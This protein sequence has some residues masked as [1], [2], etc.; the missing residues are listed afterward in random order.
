MSSPRHVYIHVPFCARR[1]SYC[2][3]SIAV[4]RDVPVDDYLTS[5]ETE[6]LLRFGA[7]QPTEVDTIYFGGGT[8]SRL[9]GEGLARALELV[10]RRFVATRGA[11]ITAEA[12]P[13]DMAP[14]ALRRWRA[15]GINR[16]SIGSQSFDDRVLA[17][18]HRTHDARAIERAVHDARDAGITNLS[19]DLIFALP[20]ALERDF[21]HDVERALALQP[22]HVSLY[23]LTVEPATPLGR[24]VAQGKE[25][26]QPEEGYEDEFLAAHGLLTGA[27]FEH[28]EVS[29]YARPG[30]RAVHN[31]AYWAGVP[32]VGL[33]PSAHEFDGTERRWNARAW[34]DWRRLLAQGTDPREGYES[35][36]PE[37]RVAEEV[38]LG[39][40]SD[41]GLAIPPGERRLVQP[42]LDAGWA[43]LDDDG[44]LRC[45]AH[46][47]LRLDSLA[48]ALTHHRSR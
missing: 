34:A 12:N 15:A 48:A 35:L 45:T 32:Y 11:E 8:P 40:R 24:W 33:G 41:H 9:G 16:L 3:F 29:N 6:L 2:D 25:S 43:T 1:C 19:L 22:D 44:V 26:E 46:G 27:G 4:R 13:D 31:S 21:R 20:A 38:Y 18:M 42:W 37:N 47:W 7:Q 39:L 30:R 14:E 23:G 5:L 17:W 28:Y 36:T 10:Q